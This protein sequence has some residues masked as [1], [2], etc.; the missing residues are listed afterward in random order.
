MTDPVEKRA[1]EMFDAYVTAK[2]SPKTWEN[3]KRK[4]QWLRAARAELKK[5]ANSNRIEDRDS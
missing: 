3:E 2:R 5:L 1:K 4:E